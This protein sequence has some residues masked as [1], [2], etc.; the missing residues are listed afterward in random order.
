LRHSHIKKR[1]THNAAQVIS[2]LQHNFQFVELEEIGV[3][4]LTPLQ[5]RHGHGH[6]LVSLMQNLLT[7]QLA[8]F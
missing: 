3:T 8:L 7:T 2:M 1:K 6:F 5:V 4:Y